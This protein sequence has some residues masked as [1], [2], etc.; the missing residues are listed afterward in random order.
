MIFQSLAEMLQHRADVTP[1]S[2]AVSY[3][4]FS[5][6]SSVCR[7]L[8]YEEL[9][10]KSLAV[11][12]M[13]RSK[14]TAGERALLLY[15]SGLE[16]A[17]A[18]FGC[19]YA[20]VIAVPLQPPRGGNLSHIRT[21]AQNCEA[22][23]ALCADIAVASE[24]LASEVQLK[25]ANTSL[26]DSSQEIWGTDRI[27]GDLPALLQYTSGSL[28]SPKGVR[29]SHESALANLEQIR[30]AFRQD[31]S[32]VSVTWLPLHH[33]M[34]LIGTLLLPIY[35]GFPTILMSPLAFLQRPARWL[36]AIEQFSATTAGAPAFGYRHCVERISED[37]C[38]DLSLESWRVAF[39]GAEPIAAATLR[40]FE[41][42][43]AKRGFAGTSFLPCYGLA[44]A[45]LFVSGAPAGNGADAKWFQ[46]ASLEQGTVKETPAGQDDA[47][48]IVSCGVV[49]EGMQIAITDDSDQQ[50]PEGVIGEIR[51]RGPNLSRGYWKDES[52]H[53]IFRSEVLGS[54]HE[55]LRTGDL[56][57]LHQGQLYVTGRIKNIIIVNGR[58][59]S[60]EDIEWNAV[61]SDRDVFAAVAIAI[62][63]GEEQEIAVLLETRLTGPVERLHAVGD[64]ARR[65]ISL[66]HD[67]VITKVVLL[68]NAA[69]PRTTSGKPARARCRKEFLE[70]HLRPVALWSQKNGWS[71]PQC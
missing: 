7:S 13:L 10:S 41:G 56:G 47:R 40:R 55:W 70:G 21:V 48:E 24:L 6:G 12:A 20:G 51:V 4:D 61:N 25:V 31:T 59:L 5:S 1:G 17:V 64:A 35:A 67:V 43:F 8:T 34:G 36:R 37:A 38:S 27:S 32:S 54:Q 52:S 2:E 46:V 69:L 42:K 22:S 65:V 30:K 68:R 58:N 11:A 14:V 39:C 28:G 62:E 45:T 23:I 9:H 33:D 66:T 29:V 63:A 49:G 50:L 57:F 60:C 26:T 18:F 16:F 19:M 71:T 15:P 3:L 44:E 53:D